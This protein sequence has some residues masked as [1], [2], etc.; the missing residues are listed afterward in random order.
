MQWLPLV[1]CVRAERCHVLGEEMDDGG[2]SLKTGYGGYVTEVT[3][4]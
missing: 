2:T 3:A 4:K 1:A